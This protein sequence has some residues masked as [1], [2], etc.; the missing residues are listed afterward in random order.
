MRLI[1][2]RRLT[3]LAFA[4]GLVCAG[5][6]A[7]A[8]DY[9][10]RPIR[11]VVPYA[12]GGADTYIRPLTSSLEKKHGITLVI[13]TVVGAGGVIGVS[14]VKRSNPDGYTLLFC[15][16]GAL[17]IAPKMAKTEYGIADFSP[18]LDLIA[19]PYV[20]AI[21]KD[22]PYRTVQ[23]MI[24]FA[25]ANPGKIT[26]GTPGMGSAP[27]L[28]MED[29]ATRLGIS[30]THVPFSGISTAVTSA[31]GGHID[32]VIG[33]PN[34]V[35][36]QVRSGS[37]IAIG[38]SA[39]D[40]FELA[41]EIPTIREAGADVDVSTNFG[42]LAPKGTPAPIIEK[43]AGAIRDAAAEPE[44]IELMKGMQ[45][46]IQVLSATEFSALLETEAAYFATVIAKLPKSQ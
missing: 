12:A 32:A 43:L 21:K 37:L 36:P 6:Q 19:I 24:E 40:R 28:A 25:R 13:E 9:P 45:N 29:M 27:H 23:G 41:P 31:M 35:L 11:V 39:R 46:R 5:G 7:D 3:A 4:A 8:A 15:G 38:I 42:F 22:A 33:A 14:Q 16:S 2:A 26:Y 18:I 17:T 10:T 20:L 30:V 44:F 1:A 34:N